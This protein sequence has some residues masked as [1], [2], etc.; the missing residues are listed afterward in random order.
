[1]LTIAADCSTV[2]VDKNSLYLNIK[3]LIWLLNPLWS[4]VNKSLTSFNMSVAFSKVD[5]FS[6]ALLFITP[7]RNSRSWPLIVGSFN[8]LLA[9]VSIIWLFWDAFYK[10]YKISAF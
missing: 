2:S 6:S 10:W 4:K 7:V 3:T 1:M 5:T 9:N 8:H